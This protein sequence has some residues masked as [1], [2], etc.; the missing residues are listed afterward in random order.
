M[1]DTNQKNILEGKIS[2]FDTTI[3]FFINFSRAV[4]HDISSHLIVIKESSRFIKED[5]TNEI[6]GNFFDN[7][8]DK[9]STLIEK[10]F[11]CLNLLKKYYEEVS[12]KIHSDN[13]KSFPLEIKLEKRENLVKQYYNR[14]IES[15]DE[16]SRQM[17]I[18]SFNFDKFV[19]NAKKLLT[20]LSEDRE[21]LKNSINEEINAATQAQLDINRI[22]TSLADVSTMRKVKKEPVQVTK[23]LSNLERTLK[24]SL[25]ASGRG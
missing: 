23:I 6:Q 12:E 4:N 17:R 24:R 2:E 11:T 14:L 21:Y 13:W 22:L 25:R 10:N 18:I 19:V 1:T 7:H 9:I 20:S 8:L 16:M 15:E 5:L 3:E